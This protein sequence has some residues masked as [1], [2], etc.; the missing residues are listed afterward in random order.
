MENICTLYFDLFCKKVENREV[1]H[2]RRYIK[3]CSIVMYT[4]H[5]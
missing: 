4:E 2:L 5:V 3:E 1:K